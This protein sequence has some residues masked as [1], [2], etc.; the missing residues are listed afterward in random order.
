MK[1]GGGV[2]ERSATLFYEVRRTALTATKAGISGPLSVIKRTN[3][4]AERPEA[5]FRLLR[6]SRVC[7]FPDAEDPDEQ[8]KGTSRRHRCTHSLC[9]FHKGKEVEERLESPRQL[10]LS[11]KQHYEDSLLL[12]PR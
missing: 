8:I 7:P 11:N 12:L 4:Q 5:P 10:Q 6:Y 2:K 3:H 9:L 1:A